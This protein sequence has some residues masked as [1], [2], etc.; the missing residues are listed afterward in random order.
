MT[1]MTPRPGTTLECALG[2]ASPE[3]G[4]RLAGSAM[5]MAKWRRRSAWSPSRSTS[6][7]VSSRRVLASYAASRMAKRSGS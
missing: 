2:W 6:S 4:G 5:W 1:G 7:L 3:A